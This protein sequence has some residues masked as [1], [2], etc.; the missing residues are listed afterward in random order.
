MSDALTDISR[1]QERTA[2]TGTYLRT[3]LRS[4]KGED[5]D[6]ELSTAASACD[7]IR[8]GSQSR[9]NFAGESHVAMV[10]KLR[11]GD[12]NAWTIFLLSFRNS[13]LFEEFRSVSPY[14]D[15][16]AL[17]VNYV[18]GLPVIDPLGLV[19][20]LRKP[21]EALPKTNGRRRG[22]C[23]LLLQPGAFENAELIAPSSES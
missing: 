17:R 8:G 9:T 16:I 6:S 12:K 10:A 22:S 5:C 3:L 7:G 4:L 15:R 19:Q 18:N 14:K 1:D 20:L 23:L 2:A 11:T 21:S 13:D